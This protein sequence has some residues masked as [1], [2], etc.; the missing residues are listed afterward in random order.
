MGTEAD[1]ATVQAL[2]LFTDFLRELGTELKKQRIR[3]LVIDLRYNGGGNS[4]LGD[5]LLQFLGINL[6]DIH[7]YQTLVRHSAESTSECNITKYF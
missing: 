7:T 4:L 2:P 6:D 5:Q 1:E 3:T